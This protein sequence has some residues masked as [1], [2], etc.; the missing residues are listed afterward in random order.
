MPKK[1]NIKNEQGFV[2]VISL[3]LLMVTTLM[4]TMLLLSATNESKSARSSGEKQQ[5]FLSADS[6]T[7][8]AVNYLKGLA[9][10]GSFPSN[11]HTA[12]SLCDI[13]I[14]KMGL[15]GYTAIVNGNNL[16][17]AYSSAQQDLTSDTFYDKQK[18]QYYLSKL[19]TA[20]ASGAGA[21]SEVGGGT[22]YSGVGSSITL[23]YVALSCGRNTETNMRSII[24]AMMSV[25]S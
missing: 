4:G 25:D 9:S 21:G 20:S 24:M 12:T 23:R 6:G 10:S 8:Y 5:T 15:A 3:M 19:E 11:G 17:Y 7:Q 18:Y 22:I 14:N 2:L 13:P 1:N 16:S